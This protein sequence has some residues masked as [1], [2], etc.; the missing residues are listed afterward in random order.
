MKQTVLN[1]SKKL[2]SYAK[3][4]MGDVVKCVYIA[5]DYQPSIKLTENNSDMDFICLDCDLIIEFCSGHKMKIV[6]SEWGNLSKFNDADT[7][8]K[9]EK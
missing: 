1:E 4:I 6:A 8:V 3:S 2:T 7:V 9:M 5:T